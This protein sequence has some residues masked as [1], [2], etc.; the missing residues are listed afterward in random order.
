MPKIDELQGS[1]NAVALGDVVGVGGA[2]KLEDDAPDGV[3]GAARVVN[4]LGEVLVARF[5]GVLLEGGE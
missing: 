4:Q 3:G 1:A 5:F 2:V